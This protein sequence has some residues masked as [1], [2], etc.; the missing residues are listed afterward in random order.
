[1]SDLPPWINQAA[2]L[3]ADPWDFFATPHQ[4]SQAERR[5]KDICAEC[6]ARL[7]CLTW[8]MDYEAGT[9]RRQRHGIFGG[10]NPSERA[11]LAK[12]AA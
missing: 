6:P 4:D 11:R 8:Q 12:G 3:E 10:L 1:M 5:A 9:G 2:C 7:K